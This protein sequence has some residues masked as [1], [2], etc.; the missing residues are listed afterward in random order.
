MSE[1][2]KTQQPKRPIAV[3]PSTP[4]IQKPNRPDGRDAPQSP[5]RTI[6]R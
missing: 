4:G 1:E 2:R 6:K 5:V 3:N